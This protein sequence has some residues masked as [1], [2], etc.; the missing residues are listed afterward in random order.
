MIEKYIFI[1]LRV[2]TKAILIVLF[3]QKQ[4]L[5]AICAK[6]LHITRERKSLCF[7]LFLWHIGVVFVCANHP[8]MYIKIFSINWL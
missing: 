7:Y 4:E 3:V 1:D 2:K 5:R 8:E 6:M